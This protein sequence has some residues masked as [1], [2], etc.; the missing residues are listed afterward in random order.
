MLSLR[1]THALPEK[2]V[3][4]VRQLRTRVGAVR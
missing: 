1:K 3:G 4:T 2:V